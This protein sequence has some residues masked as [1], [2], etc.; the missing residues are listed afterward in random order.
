MS[1]ATTFV[2]GVG[3]PGRVWSTGA[4]AFIADVAHDPNFPRAATAV[5]EGLHAAFGFPI[6]I[7]G[8]VVGVMEFFSRE[9]HEP[10]D[11]LLAML[12]TIGSQIGQF[13]ERRRAEEELD[14]FFTLSVDLL[15]I[16]G[17][18]GRFK[19]VNPSWEPVLGYPV[20]ELCA[21]PYSEFVHPDDRAATVAEHAK[22]AAGEQ[23]LHYE[24]RYRAKDGTYRWLS[25]TA[26]PYADE[27]TIYAAGARRHGATSAA[28][29]REA[30]TERRHLTQL[31]RELDRAKAKA[32]DAARAKA[33]FLANMSHEIRTPM[34][35]II[36]MTEL[37]LRH[38]ADAASSASTSRWSKSSARRC[39]RYQRHPR[40]LEDRGRQAR[41]SKRSPF[42]LR[43]TR[44]ATR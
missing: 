21:I 25:W 19:R 13:M 4:P 42:P 23:L 37:A 17:F 18:D 30:R 39:S 14:R 41:R 40:L 20:Q 33:E 34:N 35:G 44:R 27:R 16:A 9:I 31:V 36:G 15:C 7:A 6:V 29:E 43:D 22:V 5:R 28:T 2:R 10:D 12:S 11:D 38:R 32:E 24:N 1:R 8:D 3:L 26:V